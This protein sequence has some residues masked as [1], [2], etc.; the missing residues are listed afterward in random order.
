MRPHPKFE[1]LLTE[2][3]RLAGT[4]TDKDVDRTA[5]KILDKKN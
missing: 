1:E 3:E 4:V 2:L 5:R